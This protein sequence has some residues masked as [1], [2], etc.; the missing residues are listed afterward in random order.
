M[1]LFSFVKRSENFNQ[2]KRRKKKEEK[3]H[4]KK[5]KKNKMLLQRIF[6]CYV[7]RISIWGLEFL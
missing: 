5:K 4:Y 6:L 1:F 7:G 2:K 3:K